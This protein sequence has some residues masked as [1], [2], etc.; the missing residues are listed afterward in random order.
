MRV[1]LYRR[2]GAPADRVVLFHNPVYQRRYAHWEVFLRSLIERVPVALMAGP[3]HF[4]RTGA[5]RFPG[6]GTINPNP[7]RLY[8]SFRQWCHDHHATVRLLERQVQLRV[9]AEIGFSLGGFQILTLASAG[10][11]DVPMVTMSA[12]NRYAWGLWNGMMGQNLKAGMQ[13]VGIDYERLLE[14]TREL[15]LERHVPAL[16]GRPTMYVY[17]GH[18]YV[19]PPP[20]LERL[21]EALQPTR[22]LFLPRAGHGGVTV[23]VRRVMG[24]VVDFLSETG[25]LD[26]GP[27]CYHSRSSGRRP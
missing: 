3:W 7:Y 4:E 6:E 1:R 25:A 8:E 12:T 13:A 11:I 20:S 26:Q 23:R 19:D 17:G 24:G 16:R 15:Q 5:G 9:V 18:D 2:Q 22:T 10:E 21:R 27:G 14:M